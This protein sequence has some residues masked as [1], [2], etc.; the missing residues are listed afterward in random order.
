MNANAP[1]QT[2]R[3]QKKAALTGYAAAVALLVA[4]YH[5]KTD[6]A[7][8]K[9]LWMADLNIYLD[10][11]GRMLHD[12]AP[13]AIAPQGWS[14][15]YPPATL[16][17]FAPL[18]KL[19]AHGG[20]F[21][22]T[23]V[24]VAALGYVTW[25]VLRRVVSWPPRRVLIVAVTAVPVLSWFGPVTENLL[26]GQVDLIVM[27]LVIADFAHLRPT[28]AHGALIALA[29]AIKLQSGLFVVF[30]LLGRR[31]RPA[32]TA[33]VTFLV[34]NLL[35]FAA[36]PGL[37]RTYWGTVFP[38]ISDRMGP[39]QAIYSGSFLSALARDTHD[40]TVARVIWT[41]L[42]AA[43]LIA[44]A[45]VMHRAARYDDELLAVAVCGLA[46]VAIT[47]LAWAHYWVWMVP[48]AVYLL[49]R[50]V[51]RRSVPLGAA[52]LAL[53][54][55][56]HARAYRF[57]DIVSLD[58]GRQ[59]EGMNLAQQLEL[60]A[61]AVATLAVIPVCLYYLRLVRTVGTAEPAVR[62]EGKALALPRTGD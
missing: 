17:L 12:A 51:Q 56:F 23:V 61:Y 49:V 44:V 55:V 40:L 36:Q 26:L 53:V 4:W 45:L 8:D 6:L 3:W 33:T 13:Y 10:A 15:L 9:P 7:L 58:L 20:A 30:L 47:S 34:V 41:P 21:L 18:T 19:P 5:Y 35:S 39:P 32:V 24:N 54:S 25:A 2:P 52:V 48:L 11:A 31:V 38:H 62:T 16:W 29:A 1:V 59:L 27:A 57:T 37:S 43:F 42:C 50:A 22:F 46:G 14:Y 28:R 60:S